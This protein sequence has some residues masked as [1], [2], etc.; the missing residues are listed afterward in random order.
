VK[1]KRDGPA[2]DHLFEQKPDHFARGG[3]DFLGN[4]AGLSNQGALDPHPK[5]ISYVSI[6]PQPH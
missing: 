5:N 2:L 1:W 3:A 4:L 6:V